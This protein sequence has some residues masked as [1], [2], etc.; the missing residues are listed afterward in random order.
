[1]F[2][3]LTG[4]LLLFFLV[5]LEISAQDSYIITGKIFD[6]INNQQL[7]GA[8]IKIKGSGS[9]STAKSDGSFQLKSNQKLPITL[10]ISSIGYKTQ[11]FVVTDNNA[12][13]ISIALNTQSLLIDPV[14][15]TA[16]R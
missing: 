10:I 5:S 15:V 1:M 3:K 13:A 12:S 7:A 9:G 11:E 14:V 6:S 16:S 2:T 4:I 8:S